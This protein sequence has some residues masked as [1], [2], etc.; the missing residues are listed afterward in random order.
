MEELKRGAGHGRW[1]GQAGQ[2]AGSRQADSRRREWRG[3]QE[4]MK[5][6]CW[7]Q[8]PL[9]RHYETR[10]ERREERRGER[11]LSFIWKGASCEPN[12]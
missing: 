9:T 5:E 11:W 2:T 10:E 1:R 6:R 7:R 12:Q 3:S 4:I 8:Q